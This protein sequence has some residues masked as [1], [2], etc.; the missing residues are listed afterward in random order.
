[1][2]DVRMAR[3]VYVRT[4]FA[5]AVMLV[6]A[7]RSRVAPNPKV[8]TLAGTWNVSLVSGGPMQI[9]LQLTPNGADSVF[10]RIVRMLSGDVEID[11]SEYSQLEGHLSGDRLV[12]QS[13]STNAKTVRFDLLVDR[14]ELHVISIRW[15]GDELVTPAQRWRATRGR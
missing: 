2:V 11:V 15:M 12:L 10:G 1:M 9:G 5:F 3:Q 13:A 7:C 14:E 4:L 6:F 8:V